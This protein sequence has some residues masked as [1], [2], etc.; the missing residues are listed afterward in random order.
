MFR[1]GSHFKLSA[2][3]GSDVQFSGAL[4]GYNTYRTGAEADFVM[5][6]FQVPFVHIPA[7]GGYAP[8]T[9][10]KL[11]YDI[12][13]RNKLYTLNSYRFQYGY[14]WKENIQKQH[15]LYPISINYVQPLNVTSSYDSLEK[16]YPGLDKA[17]QSQFILGSTYQ[18]TYNQ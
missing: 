7:Y 2:Y 14:T 10:I 11:G 5:P 3:V 8:R 1:N 9:D 16:I 15:E 12:L 13:K 18:F 6:R 17:I 4:R